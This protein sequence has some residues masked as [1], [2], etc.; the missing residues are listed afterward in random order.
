M[1]QYARNNPDLPP[2]FEAFAGGQFSP[3]ADCFRAA[4][5]HDE[6]LATLQADLAKHKAK[7]AKIERD[8][9]ARVRALK[10]DPA[11]DGV[12]E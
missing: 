3:M 5:T 9:D 11:Q 4:K 12:W 1:S 8:V 2:V 10:D 6:K 7:R